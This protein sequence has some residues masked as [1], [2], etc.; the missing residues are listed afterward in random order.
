MHLP[1]AKDRLRGFKPAS[2]RAA[3]WRA[4]A[5]P[6]Q[7]RQAG[8][9]KARPG[10]GKWWRRPEHCLRLPLSS[11]SSS[12]CA[13]WCL[14][15]PKQALVAAIGR[16]T[17]RVHSHQVAWAHSPPGPLPPNHPNPADAATASKAPCSTIRELENPSNSLSFG[18]ENPSGKM[19]GS[20][21]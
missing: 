21:H 13:L 19:L 5:A 2:S 12:W 17:G 15:P 11:S 10:G 9:G 8:A 6:V 16:S 3:R 18:R 4:E 1:T 20:Q 7:R 14:V